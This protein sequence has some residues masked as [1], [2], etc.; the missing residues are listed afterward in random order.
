[1][2]DY[3]FRFNPEKAKEVL[4]YIISHAPI[5]DRFH[6]CKILYF[7]DRYHLESRMYDLIKYADDGTVPEISVDD[8][9]VFALREANLDLLSTSDL[10]A[11]DLAIE[12]F[13][14]M[15]FTELGKLSHDDVVWKDVTADGKLIGGPDQPKRLP[16]EFKKIVNDLSDSE[17]ITEYLHAYY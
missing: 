5:P 15:S 16:I 14:N 4:I 6:A 7:A 8:R 1:M 11:L 17:A 10:E 9:E 2:S 12:R 3:P 13:G